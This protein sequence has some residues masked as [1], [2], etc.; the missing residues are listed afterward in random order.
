MTLLE[1]Q[2]LFAR[3]FAE[4][5]SYAFGLGY[6]VT[7]GEVERSQAQAEENAKTG[8]G[9]RNSLHLLRLAGDLHL[10]KEGKYLDRSEDHKPLGEYWENF[11]TEEA[12][13]RWG[14]NF[15]DA[16]GNPKPDGNHYS[17]EHEGRA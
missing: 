16:K 6:E 4:L 1:K 3:R 12:K 15:K 11:S 5:I 10:F 14:G 2:K 8:K 9:I 7:I 13:F 17:I